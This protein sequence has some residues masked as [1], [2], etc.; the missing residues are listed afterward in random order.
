MRLR[1]TAPEIVKWSHCRESTLW[2]MYTGGLSSYMVG[3]AGMG[4]IGARGVVRAGP[5]HVKSFYISCD[6]LMSSG[7]WE[8]VFGSSCEVQASV[9]ERWDI[10]LH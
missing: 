4:R 6:I 3:T 1:H 10:R 5:V 9:Y 7:I 8:R 2:R